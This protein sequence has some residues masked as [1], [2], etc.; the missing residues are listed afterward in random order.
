MKKY[1]L[2]LVVIFALVS[3]SSDDAQEAPVINAPIKQSEIIG[4]WTD[5]D[6]FMSFHDNHYFAA[7]LRSNYLESGLYG[8]NMSDDTNNQ[9][10]SI[11]SNGFNEKSS[12]QIVEHNDSMLTIKMLEPNTF[13]Q[14]LHKSDIMP[15]SENHILYG[16]NYNSKWSNTDTT[17]VQTQFVNGN[18]AIRTSQH[19]DANSQL[20]LRY[21]F[22]GNRLYYKT[23]VGGYGNIPT[24]KDWGGPISNGVSVWELYFDSNEEILSHKVIK[25]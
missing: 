9:I 16:K 4:V 13:T 8:Y 22:Y 25:Q 15:T 12:F 19:K 24:Q 18:T 3:C 21:F 11:S 2:S 17:T 1:F 7:Y 20:Y 10:I 5:G 23:Y 6:Y 14:T